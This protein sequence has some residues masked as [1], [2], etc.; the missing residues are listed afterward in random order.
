MF[1]DRKASFKQPPRHVIDSALS[2]EVR[3]NKALE[4]QKRRR[5]KRIE[6]ERHIDLF[7]D[8]NLGLSDD[9]A[10]NNDPNIVREG[11]AQLATLLPRPEP[12]SASVPSRESPAPTESSVTGAPQT[13]TQSKRK[14]RRKKAATKPSSNN[15]KKPSPWANKCMYAELLEMQETDLWAGG[16]DGLPSD[17]ETGWVA[18]APV[19]VGKRCLAI[20]HQGGG[21]IGAG[22]S[23]IDVWGPSRDGR[24]RLTERV[25]HLVLVPNTTIR[26]RVLGKPLIPRF[27]SPLPSDTVLDCILDEKWKENGVLHV[28]DVIKW[29]GQDIADCESSFRSV[30]AS[31]C[32]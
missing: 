26:S 13:P 24:R 10:E 5:A 21:T 19:P 1:A 6:S 17:L 3:R 32:F 7:A 8:L 12:D 30:S 27:P 23:S 15:N 25:L 11:I 22:A 18:L 28:L 14:G 9:E 4:E 29:K 16:E 20:S 2:Q 31:F